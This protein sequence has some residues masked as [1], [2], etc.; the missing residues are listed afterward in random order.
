MPTKRI[1]EQ[2]RQ[3]NPLDKDN[4]H[5]DV[6]KSNR[7]P[8]SNADSA[9]SIQEMVQPKISSLGVL[10]ARH[11]K[12]IDKLNIMLVG[13][14]LETGDQTEVEYTDRE[15]REDHDREKVRKSESDNKTKM[16]AI[17]SSEGTI[18]APVFATR[19]K[20][21]QRP[22]PKIKYKK[23]TA[24]SSVSQQKKKVAASSRRTSGIF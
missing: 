14:S 24:P 19:A 3:Y 2:W 20:P 7:L 21:P 16:P 8:Y 10:P 5:P 1:V 12:D 23:K 9:I 4:I 13:D 6:G 18:S 22:K 11:T 15:E 17:I